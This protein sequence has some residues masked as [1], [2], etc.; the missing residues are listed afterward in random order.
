MRIRQ[1]DLLADL[2]H[3][4]HQI[5]ATVETDFQSLPVLALHYKP[6]PAQWSIVE[7]LEHL[8]LYGDY[9]LPAIHTAISKSRPSGPDT[10]FKS[11]WL[12]NYFANLMLGKNGKI[13][14]MSTPKNKN[15]LFLKVPDTVITRFLGQQNEYLKLLDDAE[16][17][18][19]GTATVPLSIVSWISFKL[20]DTLRFC[21]YHNERHIAQAERVLR[22]ATH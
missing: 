5:I 11:G 13:L 6:S 9:Y 21:I 8:N 19:T 3:R 12:G 1:T 17:I 7:C 20:G 10:V 4:T 2:K 15:P 16:N 14:K 18:H 22:E